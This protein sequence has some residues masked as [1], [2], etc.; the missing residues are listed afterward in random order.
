MT[1]PI[2]LAGTVL[3]GLGTVALQTGNHVRANMVPPAVVS[4]ANNAAYRDGLYL[5]KLAAERGDPYRASTG[6]WANAEDRQAFSD[7]YRQG[8]GAAR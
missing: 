5:G 7:G 3:L 1:K 8:Y 4:Q 6:R 2:L